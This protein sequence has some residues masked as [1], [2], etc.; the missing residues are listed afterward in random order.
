MAL[1]ITSL[2]KKDQ[3]FDWNSKAQS[4]FESLKRAFASAPILRH[5]DPTLPT[6]IEADASDYAL[7][8]VI[9]QRCLDDGLLHPITFYSRKFVPIEQNYEIYDKEMLAIVETM[10][11]FRHYF[12]GLG[13]KTT[14]YSDHRNL[15][16]FTET[17]VY[18]RHQVRWAEKLSRFDFVII[19]R[20]GKQGGK[21][22][23]L[24]RRP[25]YT[26]GDDTAARTITFLKPH[27][28]DTSS[29][30]PVGH[31]AP[32]S[33]KAYTLNAAIIQPAYLRVLG[34]DDKLRKEIL[35]NL[36][37]DPELS[38]YLPYLRDGRL[39]REPQTEEFLRNYS[40]TTDGLVL[41]NGLIYI[42]DCEHLKLQILQACHDSKTAGHLGQKNTLERVSRN[43]YW[44]GMRRMINDYV[45]TCDNCARNKAPRHRPHGLLHPLPIPTNSW[46]SVSMDLIMELPVSNGFNSILVCVDRFSKMSHFIPT[47]SDLMAEGAASLYLQNVFRLHGLPND[48]V[49]DRGQQFTSRF[50]RRL[51]ELCEIKNNYSTAYHPQSD[52]QTERTNQTLEHY[53]R[54]YC[55]HQQDD[56]HDLLPYAE[57]VYNNT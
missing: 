13:Q 9:S 31:G 32:R 52:G 35:T 11:H 44:P 30:D 21:P 39:P 43:Y 20:P 16:W 49:S 4:E 45:K 8:A 22:D 15:L 33:I 47:N 54:T 56:W 41:K 23:A 50:T 48:I 42:P 17:R 18:N 10:D 14:V 55:D 46:K 5:F 40:I 51:L 37:R 3:K 53:L 7:G 34:T 36:D 57:F 25:D 12:E 2:L 24:S 1:P 27:H 19:F 29:L 6:V 26:S 38:A 28:V